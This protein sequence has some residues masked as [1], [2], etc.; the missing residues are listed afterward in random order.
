MDKNKITDPNTTDK[1]IL[2]NEIKQLKKKI[3]NAHFL[4]EFYTKGIDL[5]AEKIKEL[6]VERDTAQRLNKFYIKQLEKCAKQ[7][8]QLIAEVEELKPLIEEVHR[9]EPYEAAIKKRH[10]GYDPEVCKELNIEPPSSP[11]QAL[12][13]LQDKWNKMEDDYASKIAK[14]QIHKSKLE[15]IIEHYGQV[16]KGLDIVN[17]MHQEEIKNLKKN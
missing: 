14:L 11:E 7:I 12:K 16:I 10:N 5:S 9:L 17:D 15:E 13:E 1:D 3:D 2:L 6:E 8:D 4:N